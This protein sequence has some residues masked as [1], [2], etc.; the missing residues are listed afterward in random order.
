MVVQ[1][2]ILSPRATP[3]QEEQQSKRVQHAVVKAPKQ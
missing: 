2:S 1:M 3:Q